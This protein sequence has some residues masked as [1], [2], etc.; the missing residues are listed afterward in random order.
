MAVTLA[1]IL[2]KS[3]AIYGLNETDIKEILSDFIPTYS[4]YMGG[5]AALDAGSSILAGQLALGRGRIIEFQGTLR[6]TLPLLTEIG[7]NFESIVKAITDSTGALQRNVIFTPE[8]Y[9]EL[10][11]TTKVLNTE[12]GVLIPAFESVGIATAN[13]T[14]NVENSLDY[15]RSIGV[16]AKKV[17]GSVVENTDMLNRFSFKEGVLGFT[18][19]AAQASMLKID[20]SA[21]QNFADKVFEPEGAIEVASTFQ[22]L[23]IY[24]GDLIDPF[25]LLNKSLN[26][27][28]GL[29]VSLAEAGQKFTQLSEDGTRFE[30]NPS[31]INQ[32]KKMAE[33]AGLSLKDYTKTVLALTE[34]NDRISDFDFSFDISEEQK[35]FVANMAYLNKDGKYV[36]K[37]DGAETLVT[38]LNEEQIKKIAN[39]D[40]EKTMVELAKDSL[41]VADATYNSLNAIKYKIL[42]GSMGDDTLRFKEDFRDIN[43]AKIKQLSDSI[44]GMSERENINKEIYESLKADNMAD[45][46]HGVNDAFN[47]LLLNIG[48]KYGG[49][50]KAL[51]ETTTSGNQTKAMFDALIDPL[52]GVINNVREFNKRVNESIINMINDYTEGNLPFDPGLAEGGLAYEPTRVIVGDN[53]NAQID[54]EVIAPL[55][56]LKSMLATTNNVS[57]ENKLTIEVVPINVDGTKAYSEIKNYEFYLNSQNTDKKLNIKTNFGRT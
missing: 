57:S 50:N 8:I 39:S 6:D 25:A 54:P 30:I 5:L 16:D 32:M 55:S 33:L 37:L 49:V 31:A 7:G 28:Q 23:G 40:G 34:F 27:P 13:I 1:S 52:G 35:M 17:M 45:T 43:L 22:R 29:I 56:K 46:L 53:R 51:Y 15:I 19:M 2:S 21:V 26:D 3:L 24:V 44:P 14:K 4:T 9:Q 41:S 42:F 10:Y 11:A 20:M 47:D 18:K 12:L 48:N 38:S 36:I